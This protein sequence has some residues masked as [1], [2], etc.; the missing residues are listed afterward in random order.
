MRGGDLNSPDLGRTAT[1][2]MSSI[3]MN[4]FQPINKMF[5]ACKYMLTELFK[6]E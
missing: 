1:F 6:T 5:T 2:S 4:S 3:S